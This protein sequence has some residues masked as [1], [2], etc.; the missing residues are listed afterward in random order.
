MWQGMALSG[1]FFF[2]IYGMGRKAIRIYGGCGVYTIDACVFSRKIHVIIQ[3]L[4]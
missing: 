2:C 3:F 4:I 1:V